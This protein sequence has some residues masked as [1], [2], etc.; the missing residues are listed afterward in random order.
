MSGY[1]AV[2]PPPECNRDMVF[3]E[4]FATVA[5]DSDFRQ[6]K[7]DMQKKPT[8]VLIPGLLSD[9]TVWRGVTDR[10]QNV[11]SC[12]VADVT[13]HDS[14]V[15]MAGEILE[16]NE[17][18]LFVAGHS[19]GARVALEMV[20]QAPHRILRLAL[21]DTGVHPRK[22]GEEV[23]RQQLVDLAFEDGM[24]ALAAEWLPPMVH[25]NRV[26]DDE[27]MALLTDMVCRMSPEIHQRQITALLNRPDATSL[28]D[29]IGCPT[30]LVVGRQDRWSPLAQHEQMLK[31][32]PGSSLTVIEEAGHFAPV[33]QP[34]AVAEVLQ[35]WFEQGS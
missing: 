9:E 18:P 8:L 13:G 20:R 4:H 11:L 27:L 33:E 31:L 23:R 15:S 32:I 19:M 29:R 10:L 5:Q 3:A 2:R 28:L 1:L 24:K 12:R 35:L 22:D 16:R 26:N 34:E 21:L 7:A 6:S 25:E 14:L 30:L 17:G